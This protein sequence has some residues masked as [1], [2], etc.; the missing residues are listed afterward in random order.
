MNLLLDSLNFEQSLRFCG[1]RFFG[2]SK[3]IDSY[4]VGIHHKVNIKLPDNYPKL[5]SLSVFKSQF[6]KIWFQGNNHFHV[7]ETGQSCGKNA[8]KIGQKL[9]ESRNQTKVW[10]N[11]KWIYFYAIDF[12]AILF[13]SLSQK[14]D[15][16]CKKSFKVVSTQIDLLRPKK[17]ILQCRQPK[18]WKILVIQISYCLLEWCHQIFKELL[19]SK[20]PKS[21][22]FNF[23]TNLYSNFF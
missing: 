4:S 7:A 19:V 23:K 22:F 17:L 5:A 14:I 1:S 9:T 16:V 13:F 6:L 3:L 11:C 15:L 12:K 2:K 8:Q 10:K 18:L 20:I 21:F